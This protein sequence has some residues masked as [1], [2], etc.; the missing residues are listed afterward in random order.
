MQQHGS[1]YFAHGPPPPL[2]LGMGSLGQNSTFQ[3]MVM[4]HIKLK[5]I[6]NAT[7]LTWLPVDPPTPTLGM[8][9][10]GRNSTFPQHGHV[11]YQT[12]DNQDCSN[13]VAN[14]LPKDPPADPRN[15]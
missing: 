15:G 13:M 4:L 14:I 6:T 3:N 7:F 9:L 2:I 5:K 12:K 8:A 11:A 1:K 10:V